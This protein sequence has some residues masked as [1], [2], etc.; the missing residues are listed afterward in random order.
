M[1]IG[2]ILITLALVATMVLPILFHWNH[3]HVF[4]S[5][6]PGHARFH[7]ALGD[8][9]MF[10][11]SVMGLC[12]LWRQSPGRVDML[13]AT[14]VPII[15]WGSFFMASFLPDTGEEQMPHVVGIPLNLFIAGL[16]FL[17][18]VLGYGLYRR[19]LQKET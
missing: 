16:L 1:R 5:T 14:L 12:L 3:T 17:L 13:V 7:V 8:C 4:N 18:T 2:R 19:G 10:S 15:A 9:M 6:W 11:Y